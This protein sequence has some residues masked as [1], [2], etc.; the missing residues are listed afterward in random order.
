MNAI[1]F[2]EIFKSEVGTAV[3]QKDLHEEIVEKIQDMIAKGTLAPGTQ[4]PPERDLAEVFQVSRITL[5]EAIHVL[6]MRGLV[7]RKQGRGTFIKEMPGA[8]ISESIQRFYNFTDCSFR[9]VVILRSILEPQV[10][11]MAAQNATDEELEQLRELAENINQCGD[12][13]DRMAAYD[14]KFHELLAAASKHTLIHAIMSGVHKIIMNSIRE[15][16]EYTPRDRRVEDQHRKI[17]EAVCS[18]DPEKAHAAMQSH[19]KVLLSMLRKDDPD[20][21]IYQVINE[22]ESDHS[23]MED[24]S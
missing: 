4:L 11:R 12:D 14:S 7:T 15:E 24:R 18:R 19:M 13:R 23:L 21:D 22:V 5:R 6:E 3:A 16:M 1:D 20:F 8:M 9:E 10:A 2:K 17:C